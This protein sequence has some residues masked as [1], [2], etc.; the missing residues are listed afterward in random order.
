MNLMTWNAAFSLYPHATFEQRRALCVKPNLKARAK[1]AAVKYTDRGWRIVP[2]IFPHQDQSSAFFVGE[3]RRVG[4]ARCWTIRLDTAGVVPPSV[5]SPASGP[6]LSFNPVEENTW[7]LRGAYGNERSPTNPL[8]TLHTTVKF[9]VPRHAYL[10]ADDH[11]V[12]AIRE[13]CEPQYEM[14]RLICPKGCD[15]EHFQKYWT[16]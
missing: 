7:R 2:N 12:K 13:F 6:P 5:L 9:P 3:T 16:W 1:V 8:V 10:I 14:A 4:D 11:H 15:N